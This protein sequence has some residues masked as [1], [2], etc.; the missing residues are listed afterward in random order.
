MISIAIINGIISFL[1][2]TLYFLTI[3]AG[4]EKATD[5][6]MVVL[7]LATLLNSYYLYYFVYRLLFFVK[8]TPFAIDSTRFFPF[9]FL[10]HLFISCI[11]AKSKASNNTE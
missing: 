2:F 8:N 4:M 7:Y 1:L 11:I 9:Q 6:S 3:P 10:H 5:F